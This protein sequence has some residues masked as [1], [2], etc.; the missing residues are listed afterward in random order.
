MSDAEASRSRRKV[1]KTTAINDHDEA[2]K[3]SALLHEIRMSCRNPA[4]RKK[5]FR[6]TRFRRFPA[7][8]V[9]VWVPELDF[10]AGI[11]AGIPQIPAH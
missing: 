1:V 6:P 7:M 8:R 2:I 10:G 4:R 9:P 11:S 3:K 5:W